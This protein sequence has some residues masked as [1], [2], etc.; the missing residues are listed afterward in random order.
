MKIIINIVLGLLLFVGALVGG[1]AATGRLNHEGAAN[2]PVLGSFFP[3][4]PEPKEGEGAE[5]EAAHGEAGKEA[6][7]ADAHGA[8]SG[9]PTNADHSGG[10]AAPHDASG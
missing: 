6:G 3:A 2:I 7:A 9:E 10:E 1:L 4:P 8:A 5:G